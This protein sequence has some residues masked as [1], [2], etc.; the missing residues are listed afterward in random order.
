M[1]GLDVKVIQVEL[2]TLTLPRMHWQ[3]SST[4]NIYQ[5]AL[6]SYYRNKMKRLSE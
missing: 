1:E 4:L 6:N 3:Q 5:L 2:F